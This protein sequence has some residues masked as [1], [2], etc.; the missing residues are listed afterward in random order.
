[1]L[2]NLKQNNFNKVIIFI[3]LLLFIPVIN[4][5]KDKNTQVP[6]VYVDIYINLDL[7]SYVGLNS[8]GGYMYLT[9]GSRGIILYRFTMEDFLAYDRHCTYDIENE[10]GRVSIDSTGL[11]LY[12]VDCGSQFQILDGSV[13]KEPATRPLKQYRVSYDGVSNLHIYN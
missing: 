11:L 1:M 13:Y 4:C 6:Y 9:G 3:S 5:K 8:P 12:C 2:N 7:P 10:N